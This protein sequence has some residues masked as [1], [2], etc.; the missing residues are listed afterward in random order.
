MPFQY[1]IANTVCLQVLFLGKDHTWCSFTLFNQTKL[2]L[3]P[4]VAIGAA[5]YS[6]THKLFTDKTLRLSRNKPEDRSH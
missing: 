4:S 2:T 3:L 6:S 1:D 5:I